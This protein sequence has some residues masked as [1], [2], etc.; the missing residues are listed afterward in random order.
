MVSSAEV[1]NELV[2]RVTFHHEENGCCVPRIK[3]RS[4]RDL[5]TVLS[6]A[7]MISA[8]EFGSERNPGQ[9]PCAVVEFRASSLKG[10]PDHD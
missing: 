10:T 5:I 4:Q 7:A 8:G 6:R 2:E 3:A 1:L 9:R